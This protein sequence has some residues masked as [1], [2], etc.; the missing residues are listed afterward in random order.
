[1]GHP[2]YVRGKTLKR[3]EGVDMKKKKV[4]KLKIE[5]IDKPTYHYKGFS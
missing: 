5:K 4:D 2:I 1:M 3:M